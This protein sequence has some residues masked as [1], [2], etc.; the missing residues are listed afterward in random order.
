[1]LKPSANSSR[2]CLFRDLITCVKELSSELL[3]LPHNMSANCFKRYLATRWI[4][5]FAEQ[6]RKNSVIKSR[7]V[8]TTRAVKGKFFF[9]L[10]RKS[11]IPHNHKNRPINNN[12]SF[13]SYPVSLFQNDTSCKTCPMKMDLICKKMIMYTKHSF[14]FRNGI[15]QRLVLTQKATRE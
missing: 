14:I 13:P 10:D 7:S 3:I 1:M 2:N 12:K 8:K 5:H 6:V 15:A 4:K 9:P 11:L